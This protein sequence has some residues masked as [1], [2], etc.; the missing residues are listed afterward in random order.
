VGILLAA[1]IAWQF[2]CTFED[3]MPRASVVE[4]LEDYNCPPVG[5]VRSGCLSG[6]SAALARCDGDPDHVLATVGLPRNILNNPGNLMRFDTY[7]K[8]LATAAVQTERDDFGFVLGETTDI[9]S[10]GPTGYLFHYASSWGDALAD[11]C[12]HFSNI[13][14]NA[15]FS[16][17]VQDNVARF[18]YDINHGPANERKQDCLFTLSLLQNSIR[19]LSVDRLNT[20]MDFEYGLDNSDK[21]ECSLRSVR[22]RRAANAIYIPVNWLE[23]KPPQSD[24]FVHRLIK[25]QLQREAS[26]ISRQLM[27]LSDV[28]DLLT[29]EI[30]Q[31][32]AKAVTAQSISRSLGTSERAL[33]RRLSECGTNLRKLKL[34]VVC[35]VAT[36][37]LEDTRQPITEIAFFLGYSEQS[38]FSRAF[39]MHK[40]LTPN[41][42]RQFKG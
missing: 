33:H 21:F 23:T 19:T 3:S 31:G 17:D 14:Q 29:Q 30:R 15:V 5:L 22:L 35:E 41:Q 27:L 39:K 37:L 11:F 1:M 7:A 25:S 4:K 34:V 13:Q 2:D 20:F 16:L 38:A 18:A 40:G 28:G 6:F 26:T 36:E 10:L 12:M 42:V 32:R 8:L 24:R 9:R